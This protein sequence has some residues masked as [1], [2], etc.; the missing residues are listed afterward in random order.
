MPKM[1]PRQ[2][3]SLV[4]RKEGHKSEARIYDINEI[5][6]IIADEGYKD[7]AVIDC[8]VDLGIARFKRRKKIKPVL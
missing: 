3:S 7:R 4:A 1:K 8:L 6:G 5:I 2:L